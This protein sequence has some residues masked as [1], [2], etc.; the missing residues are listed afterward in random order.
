MTLCFVTVSVGDRV[1]R[2]GGGRGRGLSESDD[3]VSL[4]ITNVI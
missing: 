1:F 4:D 2:L 3:F